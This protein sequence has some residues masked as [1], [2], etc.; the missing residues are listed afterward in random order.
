MSEEKFM[1]EI[2]NLKQDLGIEDMVVTNDDIDMLK[3][4]NN[5]EFTMNEMIDNIKKSFQI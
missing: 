1:F 2:A 5:N 4:Y 3:R